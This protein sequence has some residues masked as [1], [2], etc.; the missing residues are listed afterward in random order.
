MSIDPRTQ[1][2]ARTCLEADVRRL[3]PTLPPPQPHTSPPE[4]SSCKCTS[5]DQGGI[6]EQGLNKL[7][8]IHYYS[9][10]NMSICHVY[11]RLACQCS[12]LLC[13]LDIFDNHHP[14]VFTILI[15][16]TSNANYSD[17]NSEVQSKSQHS[18]LRCQFTFTRTSSARHPT[19]CVDLFILTASKSK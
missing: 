4:S 10:F 3:C 12:F 17:A 2:R 15:G 18:Q 8:D 14:I 5:E 19:R 13:S 1:T 11:L 16:S 7:I 6:Y 9:V